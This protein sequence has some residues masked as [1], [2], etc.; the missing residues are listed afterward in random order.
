MLDLVDADHVSTAGAKASAL[1]RAARAG[2]P[3]LPGFVLTPPAALGLAHDDA[4]ASDM[5]GASP[6][7]GLHAAPPAIDYVALVEKQIAEAEARDRAR[8]RLR[9][10]R[11]LAAPVARRRK[12][13]LDIGRE[14]GTSSPLSARLPRWLDE[15]LRREFERLGVSTSDALR[16]ILEEWW[17]ER[18]YPALEFRSPE[19]LRL[20]ALRG[21]PT[22]V[23]WLASPPGA[24]PGVQDLEQVLEYVELFRARIEAELR[25]VK[26]TLGDLTESI[27][28]LR[29]QL[30]EV[31]V[32]ADS[33]MQSRKSELEEK[34]TEFDPLEFDR[35][36][37]LQE[38]TRLMSESLHDITSIQ[39]TLV[40][41]LGETDAAV[42]A[43]AVGPV[44]AHHAG[45]EHARVEVLLVFLLRLAD[46]RNPEIEKLGKDAPGESAL[47]CLPP[48][49]GLG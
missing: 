43:Q 31:E 28:R 19:F 36:T 46:T 21:G 37:R 23:E 41:S 11:A 30:R 1:S 35:Y 39:Q 26:Q 25:S 45:A 27:S 20:A 15:Q 2:L 29:N 48:N 18:R 13:P 32:Q 8:D 33:Q 47:I 34:K 17:V 44:A 40:K 22:V 5:R 4:P 49:G 6:A 3:V 7:S 12:L 14:R 42:L 16:Q 38:L 9:R 24:A 10:L